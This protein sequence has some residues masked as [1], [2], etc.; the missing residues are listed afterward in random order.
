MDTISQEWKSSKFEAIDIRVF[1]D[2]QCSFGS[3]LCSPNWFLPQIKLFGLHRERY[4]GEKNP[5]TVFIKTDHANTCHSRSEC[6]VGT[7]VADKA[8][9]SG[10]S[11]LGL[12]LFPT[13]TYRLSDR[14]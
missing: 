10:L 12:D 6:C 13:I 1:T 4:S 8:L 7:Y 5:L 14:P 11:D 3:K 9:D 2:Y